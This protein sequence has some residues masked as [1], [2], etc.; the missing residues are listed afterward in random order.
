MRNVDRLR[1]ELVELTREMVRIPSENPPGDETAISEFVGSKLKDLG[2]EVEL[3]EAAPKRVN[4]LA[5]LKGSGGGKNFLFNG[6]YDTVP[7]G[8]LEFWTVDPFEG[9][10]K[11]GFIYGR[12]SGDMKGA[13]ASAVITAKALVDTGIKLKGNFRIHAVADE[14]YFGRYGTRYLCEKEYVSPRNVNMAVVGEGSV[15]DNIVGARTAVRGRQIVNIVVKG[16]SAHSSR[17][18]EGVNAVL[19]MSKVLLAIQDHEF[20]F[21][22]HSLLPDPTIAPG[23]L[24]KGGTKDNVIPELCEAVCD[25]RVVPGMTIEGVLQEIKDV[26]VALNEADPD[27][28]VEVTSPLAKPPSEISTNEELFQ[29][30]RSSVMEV[31]GY[32]LKPV[33]TSGSND[34]S[35]LTTIAKIPAIAFGPG[36]G[37]AHGSDEWVSEDM[38]IDFA[39]IYGL[40][41]IDICG[42]M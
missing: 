19:K 10:Y 17:P 37:N 33:G 41:V 35:W 32:E 21:P 11:D 1:N 15:Q 40:M 29:T 18:Q 27:L 7:R 5:V 9:A 24:I 6:H 8:N 36:G 25:V 31:L 34:T 12:G 14:E 26:M 2:L 16:R 13:I 30:A 20:Q 4:T 28:N 38:L 22:P 3:L 23:T 42:V 39:K